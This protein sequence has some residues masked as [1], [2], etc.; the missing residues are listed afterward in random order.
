MRWRDRTGASWATSLLYR[1]AVT[2]ILSP[3]LCVWVQ[4]ESIV[5][6]AVV[7]VAAVVVAVEYNNLKQQP[8]F[9]KKTL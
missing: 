3:F 7:V 5:S 8:L 2:Q 1:T 6:S 9:D 4:Q